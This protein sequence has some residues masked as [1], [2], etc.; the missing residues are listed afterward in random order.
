MLCHDEAMPQAFPDGVIWTTIGKEPTF[1]LI[2]RMQ[3]V[4]RALGD[5]SALQGVRTAVHQLLAHGHYGK[6]PH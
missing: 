1:D 5:E 4:R 2:I 6:K 3:E